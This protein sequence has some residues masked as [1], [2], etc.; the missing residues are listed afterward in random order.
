[1]IFGNVSV[2]KH[3][4]VHLHFLQDDALSVGSS[5]EG[6]GL[7][8]GAQVS[9]LVLLVVPLLLPAVVP[10]LPGCTQTATLSWNTKSFHNSETID[11]GDVLN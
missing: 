1:M 7:Q 8:R 4:S 6:V 2:H 10:Q 3:R 5:S 11:E 9:L